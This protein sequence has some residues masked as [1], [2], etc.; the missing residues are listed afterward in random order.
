MIAQ[1]SNYVLGAIGSCYLA[2]I[3]VIYWASRTKVNHK[4]F[5][6]E[7]DNNKTDHA[8]IRSWIE[9]AEGRAKERHKELKT[10]LK[11]VKDLIKNNGQSTPRI[12]T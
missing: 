3:G 11:E 8:N 6:V 1:I 9:D 12:R 5:D 2:V 4:T 7:R 10:D